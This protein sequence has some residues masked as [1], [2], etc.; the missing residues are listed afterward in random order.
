MSSINL[1]IGTILGMGN[2]GFYNLNYFDL[3]Q[4]SFDKE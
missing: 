3:N 2:Y 4:A 1:S